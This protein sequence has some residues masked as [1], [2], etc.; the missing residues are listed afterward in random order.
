MKPFF[1]CLITIILT[2]CIHQMTPTL[3]LEPKTDYYKEALYALVPSAI[4]GGEY[5]TPIRKYDNY[6]NGYITLPIVPI[7]PVT[8]SSVTSSTVWLFTK[9]STF[10][11]S[12]VH[13]DFAYGFTYMRGLG[14]VISIGGHVDCASA[15]SPT[16][17]PLNFDKSLFTWG[18]GSIFRINLIRGDWNIGFNSELGGGTFDAVRHE[19]NNTTYLPLDSVLPKVYGYGYATITPFIRWQPL[20]HFATFTSLQLKRSP[21]AVYDNKV[22]NKSWTIFRVGC[23]VP[24]GK[25]AA[26]QCQYG[27][28]GRMVHSSRPVQTVSGSVTTHWNT[29]HDK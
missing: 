6:F 5:G 27:I 22:E 2:G 20:T 16:D 29:H 10:R 13:P 9:V 14:N 18:A 15:P 23:E 17:R 28:S 3:Q 12:V 1:M 7:V 26:F 24:V 11:S 19:I 8:D 4:G 25:V 21:Y